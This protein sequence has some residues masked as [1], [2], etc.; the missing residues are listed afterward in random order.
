MLDRHE[1]YRAE[2]CGRVFTGI[3]RADGPCLRLLENR[4]CDHCAPLGNALELARP[5]GWHAYAICLNG[6]PSIALAQFS[7]EDIEDLSRQ[8]GIPVAGRLWAF[9]FTGSP[10]WRALK[11]WAGQHPEIARAC[12][13]S[14]WSD[15]DFARL[16]KPDG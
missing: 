13:G 9:S 16:D 15:T 2:I 6:Q 12:L 8:F 14:G 4:A 11:R 1:F 5:A 10:A 3:V 7:D